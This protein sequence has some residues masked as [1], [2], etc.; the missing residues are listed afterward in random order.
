MT[1]ALRKHHG[2]EEM[3]AISDRPLPAVDAMLAELRLPKALSSI[4]RG[5]GGTSLDHSWF[6]FGRT[7]R[8]LQDLKAN[9]HGALSKGDRVRF[10]GA[11]VFPY[12][13]GLRLHF[14]PEDQP[15]KDFCLEFEGNFAEAPGVVRMIN[16]KNERDFF[17]P[18]D[19]GMHNARRLELLRAE[20]LLRTTA[21]DSQAQMDDAFE[22]AKPGYEI[23]LEA[24][25][26]DQPDLGNA[27][28]SHVLG[29][30][31]STETHL[32][33]AHLRY[34]HTYC[35]TR[36]LAANRSGSLTQGDTLIF[37]GAVLRFGEELTLDFIREDGTR[38]DLVF[39]PTDPARCP[40]LANLTAY[41]QELP[42]GSS[43]RSIQLIQARAIL[44]DLRQQREAAT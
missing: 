14:E 7:Y 17:T 15:G 29:D 13:N 43:A 37:R 41:L 25:F 26:A 4:A 5:Q 16:Q 20:T 22:A 44:D 23:Q 1:M 9:R 21:A 18:S 38:C 11:Y 33:R 28:Y 10:L 12:D 32:D 2:Q 27:V 39:Y 31:H 6:A 19:R 3:R 36:P 35:V 42:E 40:E 24:L 30:E 34:G 8:V